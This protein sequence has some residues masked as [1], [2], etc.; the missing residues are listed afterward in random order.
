MSWLKNVAFHGL[1]DVAFVPDVVDLKSTL[2]IIVAYADIALEPNVVPFSG[3]VLFLK[4]CVIV[5]KHFNG[6]ADTGQPLSD[7]EMIF[8]KLLGGQN[9]LEKGLN[10]STHKI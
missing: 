4:E 7:N 3:V 1:T 2:L 6:E 8:L 5:A 10:I 9:I